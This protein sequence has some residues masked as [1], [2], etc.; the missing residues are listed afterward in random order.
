MLRLG[1]ILCVFCSLLLF[2]CREQSTAISEPQPVHRDL[3]HI[4][5]EGKLKALIAYSATSYFLYRGQ[6]M[7]Y[8]YELLQ[9]LADHLGVDLELKVSK[10]LDDLLDEVKN[11]EVDI[12]AHGLTITSERKKEVAFSDYLFLTKQVLV[13]KKPANWRDLTLDEINEALIQDPVEL[14]GDTISVRKNS[15]Y[16][17]RLENLSRE[18]GGTIIIDTLDG[19]MST[20]E[21]IRMVVEGKIKYT[22]ADRNLAKINASFFPSLDVSVPVSF[23]QRIA[24]ALRPSS[25]E[26]LKATNQW[27][28]TEKGG[29]DF[30]VMYN[31][32]FRN[33]RSFRRRVRSDFYSLN[34]EQISAYDPLIKRFA[35][36]LGWD[37]R[38]LAALIYQESRFNPEATSWAGAQGLMQ[39]MP[40]TAEEIGVSDLTNPEQVLEGG[41]GYLQQM[42]ENFSGVQDSVQR[43][44]FAMAAYNCGYQHIRDAQQLAIA[45]GLDAYTWD[46]HVAEMILALSYPKNYNLDMISHG[47]VRGIEPYQYVEQ[48]F[49]RYAHYASFV[50]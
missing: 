26:L 46:G 34:K 47:Y 11:G 42:Y 14:I 1:P 28:E 8:E 36:E 44:K 40:A 31:K 2:A 45:R 48:I 33:E 17:E 9:R 20:D 19:K 24:W 32:Y 16:L 27:L 22:V 7:G 29:L 50:N 13:Q 41:T 30:Y 39:I 15:S 35:A 25:T 5:A 12:V 4:K 43:I 21:I 23:S 18:I 3:A 10:D 37:W 38:L 49:E 6:P